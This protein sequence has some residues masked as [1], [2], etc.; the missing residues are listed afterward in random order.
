MSDMFYTEQYFRFQT[1]VEYI[2]L[3]LLAFGVILYI[4]CHFLGGGRD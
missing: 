1:I 2:G 3:G 4:I